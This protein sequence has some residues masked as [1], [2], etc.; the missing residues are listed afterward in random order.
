VELPFTPVPITGQTFGVLLI[1]ALLGSWLGAAAALAYWA[2]GVAGLPVFTNGNSGWAYFT[3]ATGGYIIGFVFAAYV[4]GWLSERGWDRWPWSMALAMLVG[5]VVIYLFGLPWLAHFSPRVSS[6]AVIS[7]GLLPFIP[8]DTIKLLL[9]ASAVPSGWLALHAL[10]PGGFRAGI[11]RATLPS[12]ALVTN[13]PVP[14]ALVYA[15]AGIAVIVGSLLP[16][17]IDVHTGSRVNGL[18][19]GEGVITLLMGAAMLAI[20]IAV[21]LMPKTKSEP[22]GSLLQFAASSMAAFIAFF[23]IINAV[24]TEDFWLRNPS[25][26]LALLAAASMTAFL[27]AITESTPTGEEGG[28]E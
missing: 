22:F 8:G 10:S 25:W 12:M 19:A 1:G 7:L 6:E 27:A 16:W 28:S 21:W 13:V 24:A 9:A 14:W 2:E 17:G 5:N 18:E 3:G 4:V 11:N 23:E 20:A 15:I 26:G